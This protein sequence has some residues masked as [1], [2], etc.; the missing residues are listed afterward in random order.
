MYQDLKELYKEVEKIFGTKETDK[1]FSHLL[2]CNERIKEL[3]NAR[4]NW[5]SKFMELKTQLKE[6]KNG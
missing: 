1:V 3:E 6:M 2:S 5:K 4:D